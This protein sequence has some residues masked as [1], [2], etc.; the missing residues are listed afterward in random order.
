MPRRNARAALA[1]SLL[2]S[3][4]YQPPAVPISG[5][6]ASIAALVG[7]WSG[8]YA[9][10][11]SGRSGRIF[12]RLA[13]DADSAYGDV[14]MA[15]QGLEH[16]V[17]EGR[18]PTSPPPLLP[19]RFVRAEG[20]VIYGQLAEY[21]DPE[22]GCRLKTTYTGRIAGDEIKGTFTTLHID[23]GVRHGGTWQ[24]IRTTAI[25]R[26]DARGVGAS[27][28]E[29]L[30]LYEYLLRAGEKARPPGERRREKRTGAGV[31]DDTSRP[32][33]QARNLQV[34]TPASCIANRGESGLVPEWRPRAP[35]TTT[36]VQQ[37]GP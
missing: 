11:E 29:A 36:P 9:G 25:R 19:I 23:T 13:S 5:D 22:C 16:A 20:E 18:D 32:I 35:A 7:E 12:F 2:L 17:A 14:L 4:A 30:V 34:E 10:R 8:S 31:S 6:P 37:C 15:P 1:A 21:H 24:V 26:S 33:L 28:W 27:P 3:C